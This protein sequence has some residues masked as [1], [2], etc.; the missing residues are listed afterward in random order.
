MAKNTS[1]SCVPQGHVLQSNQRLAQEKLS[2]YIIYENSPKYVKLPFP[3]TAVL[4]NNRAYFT[5]L[6]SEDSRTCGRPEKVEAEIKKQSAVMFHPFYSFYFV[7][8]IKAVQSRA[9]IFNIP[10]FHSSIS[11]STAS[12]ST[13]D[14]DTPQTTTT[15][16][17]RGTMLILLCNEDVSP[18]KT[19]HQSLHP[20]RQKG[21]HARKDTTNTKINLGGMTHTLLLQAEY[22]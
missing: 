4:H 16:V 17:L 18:K 8:E 10:I 13:L 21:Q 22:D 6:I 11:T 19:E 12:P 20:P 5:N 3:F 2:N 7:T 1:Q 14:Y 15:T 9:A